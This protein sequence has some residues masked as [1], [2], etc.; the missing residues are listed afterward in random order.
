[1]AA[2]QLPFRCEEF[3]GLASVLADFNRRFTAK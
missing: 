1:M 3:L 2:R